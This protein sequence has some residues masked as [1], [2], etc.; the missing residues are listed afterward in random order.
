MFTQ[1]F[2]NS[3]LSYDPET[4]ILTWK[5]RHP[6]MFVSTKYP[7]ERSCKSWNTRCAGKV[8]C[9][10]NVGGYLETTIQEHKVYAHRLIWLMVHGVWPCIIDHINGDRS[11]NRISNLRNGD[12]IQNQRNMKLNASNKSG[13]NGVSWDKRKGSWRVYIRDNYKQIHLG[14]FDCFEDA[15]SVREKAD[16]KY[17]FHENHGRR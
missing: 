15:K 10:K 6:S 3:I 7:K 5:E 9:S 2:L 1:E 8:A 16:I 17:K 12:R 4:G 11:D 13:V 14:N